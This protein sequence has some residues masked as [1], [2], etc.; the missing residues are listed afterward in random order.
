LITS[1]PPSASLE[2]DAA[3]RIAPGGLGHEDMAPGRDDLADRIAQHLG[4]GG[5]DGEVPADPGFVQR[6]PG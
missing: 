2:T 5:L 4:V 6:L 3:D 1:K